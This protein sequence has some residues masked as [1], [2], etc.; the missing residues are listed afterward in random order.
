MDF[1]RISTQA[2]DDVIENVF[3]FVPF[4]SKFSELDYLNQ[5]AWLMIHTSRR[6]RVSYPFQSRRQRVIAVNRE[7]LSMSI[8]CKFQ[9]V[10]TSLPN[11]GEVKIWILLSNRLDN[12]Y[13][14]ICSQ[15]GRIVV[16]FLIDAVAGL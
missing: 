16:I 1:L 7:S 15:S 5:G 6:R 12:D 8:G 13:V 10:A 4:V 2:V 9:Q 3:L 11:D 14:C